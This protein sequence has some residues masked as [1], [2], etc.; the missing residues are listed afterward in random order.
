MDLWNIIGVERLR[1]ITVQVKDVLV[2]IMRR[3]CTKKQRILEVHSSTLK[4]Q[5]IFD[6]LIYKSFK[7]HAERSQKIPMIMIKS[8]CEKLPLYCSKNKLG[9][10]STYYE[11]KK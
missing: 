6:D 7:G 8:Q 1:K 3:K 4:T 11:Y 10:V 9:V 5:L 2:L